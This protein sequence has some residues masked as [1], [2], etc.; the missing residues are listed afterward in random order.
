MA[1]IEVI[2]YNGGPNEFAWKYP[3]EE[4]GTWTQLIVNESQ[5]A[6]L[7]KGGQ[8]LDV[9]GPGRHT[10]DTANIPFLNK[11][12][13]LPFGG[14]SPFTAEVW[15][16]NKTYNLSIKWG[17]S[18]PIQIQDPKYGIF[19]SVR[20]NG[21]FGIRIG[22]S[23]RF[24]I[25]LVGTLHSVNTSLI[26]SY[27]RGLCVA[28]IKDVLSKFLVHKQVS[29]LELN[30]YIGEISKYMQE[31]LQPIMEEYGLDLVN[32]F[33]N[34]IS[35]PENDPSV[36]KLKDALSKRAEMGIV[37]YSYQ[38]E[39]S[40]DTLEGAA[41]NPGSGSA[42]IMGAGLGLGMGLGLGSGVGSTFGKISREINISSPYTEIK[43]CPN[44]HSTVQSG[45]RFCGTCGHD[46]TSRPR[47]SAQSEVTCAHCGAVLQAKGKFCPHCGTPLTKQC[48]KCGASYIG[49]PKF[50]QECGEKF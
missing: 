39:R 41:K 15:F 23:E 38:Q 10:L 17:T 40:F 13:N 21:M 37:G 45:Q 9:F 19:I 34:E 24:L 8:V 1:I 43:T 35:V 29:I 25:K 44:C 16:I 50:C 5:E 12:V 20:A 3:S 14:R 30:A 32:Y 48:P 4:L 7:V 36:K 6:V 42:P 11:I 18:S 47:E 33:V 28:E 2:K 27:F 31:R 26:T 49:S 22:N 46:L